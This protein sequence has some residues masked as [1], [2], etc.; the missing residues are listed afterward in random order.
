M[1]YLLLFIT[2]VTAVAAIGYL[3][4][5]A[6]RD[7]DLFGRIS[8]GAVAT[9]SMIGIGTFAWL[10]VTRPVTPRA[11]EAF[12]ALTLLTG[13]LWAVGFLVPMARRQRDTFGIVCAVVAA[14]IALATWLLLG[15]G[16]QSQ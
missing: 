1:G 7:T 12:F 9:I 4:P 14:L 3:I 6:H 5:N 11:V 8:A 2:I 13:S 10:V 15:T 16:V